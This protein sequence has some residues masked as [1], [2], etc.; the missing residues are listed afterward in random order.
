MEKTFGEQVI[1]RCRTIHIDPDKVI[2]ML[3]WE[4]V[5]GVIADQ[6]R[7]RN[8]TPDDLSNEEIETLLD[9]ARDYLEGKGRPPRK[10][11]GTM[12]RTVIALGI[13]DAWPA[14]LASGSPKPKDGTCEDPD[15]SCFDQRS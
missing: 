13:E 1:E 15:Q 14:R 3:F 4:D 5:L 9:K 2:Y 7:E 8:L 11:I 6:L 10:D 12:W